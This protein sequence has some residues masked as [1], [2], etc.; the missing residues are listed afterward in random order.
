M[1]LST[2]TNQIEL[3]YKP[4]GKTTGA[5]G[6]AESYGTLTYR[7]NSNALGQFDLRFK[8]RVTYEWGYVL[9]QDITVHVNS[10]RNNA[11]QK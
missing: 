4:V 1:K 3:T 9:T 8:V 7:N 11:R 2:V 5:F 6:T 10:T